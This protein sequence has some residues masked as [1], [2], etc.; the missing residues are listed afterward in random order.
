MLNMLIDFQKLKNNKNMFRELQEYVFKK[1]KKNI[2]RVNK[3][4]L[5][6]ELKSSLRSNRSSRAKK[7]SNWRKMFKYTRW[8]PYET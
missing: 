4:K 3:W 1:V 8:A 2:L 7:Y 5:N 6:I